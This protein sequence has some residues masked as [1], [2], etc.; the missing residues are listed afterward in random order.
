LVEPNSAWH[1]EILEGLGE[2][3]VVA[4]LSGRMV[5]WN[6][7]AH[8]LVGLG[9]LDVSAQDWTSGYGLFLPDGVTPFPATDLP[10]VRA[11]RGE[12]SSAAEL[13]VRNA[14]VP[15]GR[16]LRVTGRPWRDAQGQHRGGIVVFHDIGAWREIEGE[17]RRAHSFLD[18]IVEHVPT[19]IF[20]KDAESLRFERFNRAGETLL[21]MSR[22]VLLGKN[23]YDF[24]PRG[25]ADFFTHRDRETLA[26][27]AVVDIPEEQIDTAHGQRWLY[28]RKV[29]ILDEHGKPRHLLGIS[30]DI[31]DRKLAEQALREARDAL[32]ERVLQRTAE[33]EQANEELRREI[34]ERRQA[35]AALRRSEEQ[36]RQAQKM[37]AIGRL[38]GGVAH[39]FNNMLTAI[40]GYVGV[41]RSRISSDA[42]TSE[43]LDQIDLAAQRAAALTRQLLAFGRK[44]LLQPELLDMCEVVTGMSNMLQR[45][46]GE[47]IALHTIAPA[48]VGRVLADPSQIEQ[49]L[50]NLV[51]NARDAMPAG[52][53]L[54]IEVGNVPTEAGPSPSLVTLGPGDY[55]MLAVSDTGVGMGPEIKARLFE[56]FFTTKPRGRGTGLGLATVFGI[57]RQSGGDISVYSEPGQGSTFRIYLPQAK[58]QPR[59]ARPAEPLP[60]EPSARRA[61]VLLVEDEPLV[62]ETAAAILRTAG[63]TVLMAHDPAEALRI[64]RA[65]TGKIDLLL[66]DVVMPGMNGRDLA[67]E[68][69]AMRPSIRVLFMS[70]YTDNA[71]VHH[72]VLDAD[73]AFIAKP[74]TP[75]ALARKILDTLRR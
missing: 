63:H 26:G 28:T 54:T 45:L 24:F 69:T 19:M 53:K 43:G 36:L 31:T 10:L 47:D 48:N 61:N 75:D 57:V 50:L 12:A 1:R 66:T 30:L 70:G 59:S 72:G 52:G 71:I 46:I 25:Q 32:E 33:L 62:R 3:V 2:G 8:A 55:I 27:R 6:R 34:A 15:E 60:L 35:E 18:S 4:D 11:L 7:A 44:Q 56:P 37:E 13:F 22:D 38:A 58:G 17:L 14:E 21:G 29:P 16:H 67:T 40:L 41:L 5:F 68:I 20:V 49:V 51:V 23:D 73:V 74:F 65:H 42:A 9:P 39:D 64:C